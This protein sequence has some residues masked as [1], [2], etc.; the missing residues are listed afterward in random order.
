MTQLHSSE[1]GAPSAEVRF[2]REIARA[3]VQ[4]PE[5]ASLGPGR[6]VQAATYG[7]GERITGV[8]VQQSAPEVFTAEIHV[9]LTEAALQQAFIQQ[10]I[11]SAY[12]LQLA[13]A[14]RKVAHQAASR[15][16]GTATLAQID[17]AFDDVA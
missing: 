10:P 9:V 14:V 17:V 7:P 11:G 13:D 2:A 8:V 16:A 6:F 5:F 3:V 15:V 12:L 1:I 4:M